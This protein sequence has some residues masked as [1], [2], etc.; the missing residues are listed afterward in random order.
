MVQG[1]EDE[2]LHKLGLDGGGP[3]GEDGLAGEH[4]GAL[5]DSPDVAGE[6]KVLQK[7]QEFLTEAPL[8]PQIG[9]VLLIEAQLLDVLHHL[10]QAGGDGKSPLVGDGAVEHVEVTDAVL[11]AGLEVAVGHGQ[12]VEVAEHGQVRFRFH[13]ESLLVSG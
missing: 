1:E 10:G 13:R 4:R 6:S 8:A 12:L 2:R 9:R 3:D 7:G 5:R 11:Q